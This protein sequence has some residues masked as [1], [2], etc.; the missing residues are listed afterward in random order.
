MAMGEGGDDDTDDDFDD[1]FDGNDDDH[2]DD[3]FGNAC[4]SNTVCSEIGKALQPLRLSVS[5]DHAELF[6]VLSSSHCF[7]TPP[8][9]RQP[10]VVAVAPAAT[11]YLVA[12][13]N[14]QGIK[15]KGLLCS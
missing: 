12:L 14:S 5:L 6:Q 15:E 3:D 2:H 11:Y 13:A 4:S 7:K 10:L 8:H 9:N 1:Q